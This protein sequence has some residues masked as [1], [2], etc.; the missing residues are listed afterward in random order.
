MI[1]VPPVSFWK[2]DMNSFCKYIAQKSTGLHHCRLI[3]DYISVF[4]LRAWR[5]ES[6]EVFFTQKSDH[7]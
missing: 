1:M 2:A 3:F 6:Q 7:T 4:I 5:R